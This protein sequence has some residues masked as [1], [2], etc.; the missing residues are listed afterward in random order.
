MVNGNENNNLS[1]RGKTALQAGNMLV[2]EA[3][4]A[5]AEIGALSVIDSFD[6]NAPGLVGLIKKPIRAAVTLFRP[7]IEW[8]MNHMRGL[9]GTNV[10]QRRHARTEEERIDNLT[11][12]TY[13]YAAATGIGYGAMWGTQRALNHVTGVPMDRKHEA[14]IYFQDALVHAG[15]VIVLGLPAMEG[16]TQTAKDALGCVFRAVGYEDKKADELANYAM[17]VQVPNFIAYLNDVHLLHKLNAKDAI[18]A[19]AHV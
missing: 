1:L 18:L 15:A 16:V 19:A 9:E 8:A 13:H 3:A 6:R 7:Q 14:K 12:T 17:I 10:Q 2:A 4:G 11:D 5:T